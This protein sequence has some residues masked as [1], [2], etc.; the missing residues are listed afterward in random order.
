MACRQRN[1]TRD[2]DAPGG[3][4]S[5]RSY[6]C[7]LADF[8]AYDAAD[9]RTTNRSD[10][11]AAR[12]YCTCDAADSGTDRGVFV[13]RGHSRTTCQAKNRYHH[14]RLNCKPLFRFHWNTSI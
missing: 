6:F 1:G 3:T 5:T 4:P 14:K 8:V 9:C 13:L 2:S 10:S 12:Q 11:A 7:L